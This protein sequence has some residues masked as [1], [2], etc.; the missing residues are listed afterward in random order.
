MLPPPTTDDPAAV[1]LP[2]TTIY[3]V[4][5]CWCSCDIA[6]RH[7]T[8]S[9]HPQRIRQPWT[10][11]GTPPLDPA[12]TDPG[13]AISIGSDR[14]RHSHDGHLC[15][16]TFGVGASREPPRLAIQARRL[17]PCFGAPPPSPHAWPRRHQP[18]HAARHCAPSLPV[19][20]VDED[21]GGKG[22]FS[23]FRFVIAACRCN[24]GCF[25]FFRC[26]SAA[27]SSLP[28]A[29]QVLVG[30][31]AVRSG[32]FFTCVGKMKEIKTSLADKT[33]TPEHHARAVPFVYACNALCL[34]VQPTPSSVNLY[35]HTCRFH[36][37]GVFA[38]R[39]VYA[40][41]ALL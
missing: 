9:R 38:M 21:V 26:N 18:T 22:C 4:A 33:T 41:S 30:S 3:V 19:A 5:S 14:R 27:R 12:A 17:L 2:P 25:S 11:R 29:V 37:W 39:C 40:C 16:S 1:P 28:Q 36:L 15:V 13:T 6:R 20:S 8:P 23:F 32:I 10:R 31:K 35:C 7:R 34:C 24:S